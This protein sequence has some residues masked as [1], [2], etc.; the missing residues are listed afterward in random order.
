MTLRGHSNISTSMHMNNNSI[1]FRLVNFSLIAK[2][3]FN[4]LKLF[5]DK[6]S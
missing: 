3:V 2:R 4:V 1:P 5:H 6:F